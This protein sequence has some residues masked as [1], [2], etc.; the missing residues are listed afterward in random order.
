MFFEIR[1]LVVFCFT[2]LLCSYSYTVFCQNASDVIRKANELL[3][4]GNYKEAEQ[5]LTQAIKS[6]A[7]NHELYHLRAKARWEQQNYNG[8]S[9]ALADFSKAIELNPKNPILYLERGIANYDL[10]DPTNAIR[11]FNNA[12]L[13]N[14]KLAKAWYMRGLAKLDANNKE[15]CADLK[16]SIELGIDVSEERGLPDPHEVIDEKCK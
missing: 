12:I 14:E 9:G 3:E 13:H 11:D 5:L 7:S 10:N 1:Y 6:A 2:F 8:P 15:G 16:R 4:N